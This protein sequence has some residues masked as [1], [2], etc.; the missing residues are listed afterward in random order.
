MAQWPYSAAP[1]GTGVVFAV[2]IVFNDDTVHA[3]AAEPQGVGGSPAC[4]DRS[5]VMASM[6]FAPY[7]RNLFSPTPLTSRNS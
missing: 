1:A 6:N 7:W 5:C 4:H 2:A 3:I